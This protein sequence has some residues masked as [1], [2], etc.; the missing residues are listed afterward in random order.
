MNYLIDCGFSTGCFSI[1][2]LKYL[3]RLGED[4]RNWTVYGFEPDARWA[5][6]PRRQKIWHFT[7]PTIVVEPFAVWTEDGDMSFFP[8]KKR[9]SSY[10][11][12]AK[13][14]RIESGRKV[15]QTVKAI[16]LD[17]F[18]KNLKDPE[19]IVVKMDIEGGEF[20]VLPHMQEKGSALLVCEFHIEYH[21]RLNRPAWLPIMKSIKD[22]WAE[23]PEIKV[24]NHH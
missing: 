23:H 18:I 1:H 19:R 16:D 10:L 14:K 12:E 17:R 2:Y 22:W 11:A 15:S 4:L 24:I 5:Q 20:Y 6:D 3:D 13:H 21:A 8:C 7:A 9:T